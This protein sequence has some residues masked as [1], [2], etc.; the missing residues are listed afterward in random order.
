MFG[1]FER[2]VTIAGRRA[3]DLVFDRV[4][5]PFEHEGKPLHLIGVT[6]R[7]GVWSDLIDTVAG[8]AEIQRRLMMPVA[9][10][11]GL[12]KLGAEVSERPGGVH[13]RAFT[14]FSR[15]A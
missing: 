3:N 1:L 5:Q 9:R 12:E 10:I 14:A 11:G 2:D 4:R 6:G 13:K 8:S 7:E 15:R